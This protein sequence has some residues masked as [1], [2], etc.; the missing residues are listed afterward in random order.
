M[1]SSTAQFSVLTW[2]VLAAMYASTGQFVNC[3]KDALSFAY[4]SDRLFDLIRC[5]DA[6]VI[7]LQEI[8]KLDSFWYHK[9]I[10]I[11]YDFVYSK[12]GDCSVVYAGISFGYEVEQNDD[13]S[14]N[15]LDTVD[16]KQ[17]LKSFEKYPADI[18]PRLQIQNSDVNSN[19]NNQSMNSP[20][21]STP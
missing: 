11:G 10:E 20:V 16:T 6:D 4:R 2:N 21:I 15:R 5:A 14:S 9:L 17:L 19:S 12:R 13:M 7:T 8:D 18:F 1:E 3:T